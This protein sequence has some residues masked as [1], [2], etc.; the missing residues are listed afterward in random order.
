M[1]VVI[2]DGIGAG[3]N[4]DPADQTCR[5]WRGIGTGI[6]Q[7]GYHITRDRHRTCACA[8]NPI[9]G[10]GVGR[11][12][13]T[14]VDAAFCGG[15]SDDIVADRGVTCRARFDDPI[16]VGGVRRGVRYRDRTN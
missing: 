15:T 8:L 2:G 12:S 5:A 6:R 1:N 11:R 9:H 10:L 16:E 3:R 14:G 13:G 7:V 4:I